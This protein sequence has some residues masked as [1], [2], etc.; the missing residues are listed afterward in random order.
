MREGGRKDRR[1]DGR[2]TY[3]LLSSTFSLLLHNQ[4]NC[5]QKGEHPSGIQR[6][7]SGSTSKEPLFCMGSALRQAWILMDFKVFLLWVFSPRIL[8]N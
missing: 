5:I 8:S 1:K 6:A 2:T 4:Q 7:V 3:P